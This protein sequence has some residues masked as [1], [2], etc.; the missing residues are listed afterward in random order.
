VAATLILFA[1]AVITTLVA[2]VLFNARDVGTAW[3]R[4][5]PA[6]RPA[7]HRV[8]MNPLLRVPVV[9]ELWWRRFPLLFWT[10][11]FVALAAFSV[12]LLNAT[13]ELIT[14]N[15]N[16]RGYLRNLSGDLHLVLLALIWFGFAQLLVSILAMVNVARWAGEDGSGSWK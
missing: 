8:S 15:P 7:A 4:V 6:A 9:R 2:V 5:T 14:N 13:F 12:S 3:L 11:G 1:I 16:V 10:L